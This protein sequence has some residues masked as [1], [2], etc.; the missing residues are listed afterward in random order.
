[1]FPIVC[2][3]VL[4]GGQHNTETGAFTRSTSL[5]PRAVFGL[6]THIPLRPV[7]IKWIYYVVIFTFSTNSLRR[8]CYRKPHCNKSHDPIDTPKPRLRRNL[9][10]QGTFFAY[11]LLS[12]FHV[13]IENYVFKILSCLLK[14]E[15]LRIVPSITTVH[16]NNIN[17]TYLL[18]N[19]CFVR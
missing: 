17:S 4:K 19:S 13:T 12:M 2:E 3:C 9:L 10:T 16:C 15:Y 18:I 8:C 7:L 1:L 14:C 5:S 11:N 6:S